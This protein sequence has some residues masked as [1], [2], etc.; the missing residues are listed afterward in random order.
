[1]N[2]LK[3]FKSNVP[4][5]HY[6][7][8][9]LAS[10]GDRASGL[11]GGG[12]ES[13]V[14]L[15][16]AVEDGQDAGTF[17]VKQSKID[18]ENPK[19]EWKIIRRFSEQAGFMDRLTHVNI[20]GFEEFLHEGVRPYLVMEFV[21]GE[22]LR[23]ILQG[24][25][26]DE[27][28]ILATSDQ[29]LAALSYAH[30]NGVLHRDMKPEQIMVLPDENV[31]LLDFGAGK[32]FRNGSAPETVLSTAG[33]SFDY[34][35][36]EHF[37]F[38]EYSPKT[39]AYC[40]AVVLY[41]MLTGKRMERDDRNFRHRIENSAELGRFNDIIIRGTR[42]EPENRASLEQMHDV[43]RREQGLTPIVRSTESALV[44]KEGDEIWQQVKSG[45]DNGFVKIL[46]EGRKK[47]GDNYPGRIDGLKS[48]HLRKSFW[49]TRLGKK[50][51]DIM[52][53][54]CGG[55]AGLTFFG[56]WG[57]LGAGMYFA[58]NHLYRLGLKLWS[59]D[60]RTV[61]KI[62][63]F[64]ERFE[65]LLGKMDES[66]QS[67]LNEVEEDYGV[68]FRVAL[69][70]E[71]AIRMIDTGQYEGAAEIRRYDFSVAEIVVYGLLRHG[72]W[73]EA[74]SMWLPPALNPIREQKINEYARSRLWEVRE[75]CLDA[76]FEERD[77]YFEAC[78]KFNLVHGLYD[79]AKRSK[80]DE[81]YEK[82][83]VI[84]AGFDDESCISNLTRKLLMISEP[85]RAEEVI[86]IARE[87]DL[88]IEELAGELRD[89]FLRDGEDI[90]VEQIIK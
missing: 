58:G 69:E 23:K 84:Y 34:A 30:S 38:F 72:A 36:P 54:T 75:E 33:M 17:A 55:L 87:H 74:A 51:A 52:A 82:A 29:V 10:A 60:G 53:A 3:T 90:E 19:D 4:G 15:V 59:E 46:T 85:F 67:T 41:E 42:W 44:P 79:V 21:D 14:Y 18:T 47:D 80:K 49:W 76:S 8:V 62:R 12:G 1:M 37:G 16:R 78:E 63:G 28:R 73:K 2:Q 57:L 68:P 50:Q 32:D 77:S 5:R 26:M 27:G 89:Y 70:K 40:F 31:K 39:D 13:L 24:G 11:I 43:I 35:A 9:D 83:A 6:Q 61:D 45:E 56:W 81:Q 48:R 7:E 25:Q 65:T 66:L 86:D 88:R 20:V 64:E 71:H 22:D